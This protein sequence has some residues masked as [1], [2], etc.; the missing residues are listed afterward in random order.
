MGGHK[1]GNRVLLLPCLFVFLFKS[2]QETL[3]Y[4]VPRF[5]HI[6]QNLVGNM[7]RRYTKLAAHMMFHKF[8]KKF[9]APVRHHIVE[10]DAG[11]DKH[12]FH[13]GYSAECAKKSHVVAVV[14]RKIAAGYREQALPV[15]THAFCQLFLAGRLAEIRGGTSHIMDISLE[16]RILRH[17]S[18]FP[19]NGLM[20]S[21]L[22]N[23]ALV[24]SKGAETA[25]S[26]AAPVAG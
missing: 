11:T 6:I 15:G 13:T 3:I 26:E 25:S 1:V 21:C 19:D 24:K 14:C 12:F 20:T 10:T 9:P 4:F 8:M 22:Q 16:K 7:F 2:F 5:A 18:R 23:A 17:F